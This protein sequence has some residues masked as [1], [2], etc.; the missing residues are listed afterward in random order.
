MIFVSAV[1]RHR[2]PWRG[3]AWAQLVSDH[4]AGE[5]LDFAKALGVPSS[6][7]RHDSP[8]DV[9]HYDITPALRTRALAAGARAATR[10]ELATACERYRSAE[11]ARGARP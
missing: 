5:L 9:P 4:S 2:T 1:S 6:A 8:L 11:G 7:Y 3:G 10:A